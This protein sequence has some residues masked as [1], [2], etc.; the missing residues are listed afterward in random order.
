VQVGIYTGKNYI[1]DFFVV[2]MAMNSF[3]GCKVSCKILVHQH[4]YLIRIVTQLSYLRNHGEELLLMKHQYIGNIY[5]T[6][7][8]IG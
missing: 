6:Q 1:I 3:T 4:I 8:I 7:Q 2:H 5:R